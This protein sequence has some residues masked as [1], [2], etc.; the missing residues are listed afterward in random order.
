MLKNKQEN[1]IIYSFK[2]FILF[3]RNARVQSKNLLTSVGPSVI[4]PLSGES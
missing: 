2:V 3:F 4:F 1:L